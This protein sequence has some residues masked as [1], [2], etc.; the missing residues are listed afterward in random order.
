MLI[1]SVLKNSTF[2]TKI[3]FSEECYGD[4][5]KKPKEK[6]IVFSFL[7]NHTEWRAETLKLSEN[8][9]NVIRNY[10]LYIVDVIGTI[11]RYFFIYDH[12]HLQTLPNFS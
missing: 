6:K 8:V 5:L 7:C 12:T 3:F 2:P 9:F 1:T 11:C 4:K 10:I